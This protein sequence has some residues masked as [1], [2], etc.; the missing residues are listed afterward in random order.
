MACT[1]E[2]VQRSCAKGLSLPQKWTVVRV[3]TQGTTPLA[4]GVY[5]ISSSALAAAGCA[6]TYLAA[7]TCA[8]GNAVQMVPHASDNGLQRWQLTYMAGTNSVFE[9]TAACERGACN[10]FISCGPACASQVVDIWTVDDSSGRQQWQACPPP[11]CMGGSVP[12]GLPVRSPCC[13]THPAC[14]SV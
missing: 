13:C 14:Q 1:F 9:V 6:N 5:E 8:A 2:P 7:S 3:G 11:P 10:Q 4:S 12:P